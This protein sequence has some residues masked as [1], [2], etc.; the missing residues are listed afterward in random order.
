MPTYP[1]APDTLIYRWQK[2]RSRMDLGPGEDLPL[3]AD[4]AALAAMPVGPDPFPESSSGHAV[5]ARALREEFAAGTELHLLNGLLIAHLRKRR[6]P[7]G[8]RNLFHRIWVEQGE[9]LCRQLP[10]RWLISSLITFGDHGQ[11]EGERRLGLSLGVLFS[12]MK[13]YEHERL[14]SGR[15][16]STPFQKAGGGSLPLDMPGFALRSGGLDINL[17]APLWQA[18]LA[19]PVAGP[20]AQ[21]VLTRL[22]DDPRGL[23]AR[24]QRMRGTDRDVET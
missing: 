23:F 24:L 6:F 13:L 1:G 3:D 16:A 2:R 14:R 19:E 12:T 22:N 10:S 15:D 9:V 8:A 18:A 21:E 7:R 5:K 17:L 11:T 20:P 4:L